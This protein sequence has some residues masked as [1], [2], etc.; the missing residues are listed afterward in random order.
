MSVLSLKPSS[1]TTQT[2]TAQ[3]RPIFNSLFGAEPTREPA[4]AKNCSCGSPPATM[5]RPTPAGTPT[6]GPPGETTSVWQPTQ[7][8]NTDEPVLPTSGTQTA[9]LAAQ[10]GTGAVTLGGNGVRLEQPQPLGSILPVPGTPQAQAIPVVNTLET[11]APPVIDR[12]ADK[13]ANNGTDKG[14]DRNGGAGKTQDK[15]TSVLPQPRVAAFQSQRPNAPGN[16]GYPEL[17]PPL[18]THPP[19]V[20]REFEKRALSAYIIEPPDI[21]IIV[22]TEAI[23]FKTLPLAGQHLV[24]PD[25]T[26]SLGGYGDIFVAGLTLDQAKD[27]VANVLRNRVWKK[28]PDPDKEKK[29]ERFT[30]DEIKQELQV[31]V[32]VYNSKFYYVITDGGG[33]GSAVFRLPCT[34]NETVLD[35][36]AAIQGLPAQASLKKIWVARATPF[37]HHSPPMILPVDW[38]GITQRGSAA[39]NYQLFPGDRVFVHSDPL[40]RLDTRLQ[41]ILSPIDR[42]FGSILLGS[43]TVNSIKNGGNGGTGAGGIGR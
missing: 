19:S 3:H 11:A 35:A 43:S 42:V 6:A 29:G 33:Y 15:P 23:T 28:A 21:L 26:I 2:G 18:V 13:A 34:G 20:P 31:D 16:N 12:V 5:L 38:C 30:L 7:H 37:D 36:L 25:G 10:A 9:P 39:T 41:R 22:G 14:T 1:S 24:R 4:L 8:L 40:L 32:G 17:P 27:A